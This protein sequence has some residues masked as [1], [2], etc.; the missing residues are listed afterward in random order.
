MN[1]LLGYM[2]LGTILV[3]GCI[4]DTSGFSPPGFDGSMPSDSNVNHNNNNNNN[5]TC[6][7]TNGGIEICDEIDNDCNG[8]VD[9]GFDFQNDLDN[10]GSCG[11]ACTY[12]H[13]SGQCVNGN[14]QMSTCD[15]GWV[16]LN[17]DPDNGCEYMC[18]QT[19]G[20]VEICDNL[21]ND[22]DGDTDE[23]FD[24]TTDPNNCG[25]C[26][27]IC[28]VNIPNATSECSS[29]QCEMLD[30]LKNGT[31]HTWWDINND[32]TDGCE[33]QCQVTTGGH[34]VCDGLDNDCDGQIDEDC[35]SLKL[36]FQ[37]G[38]AWTTW[39]TYIAD[40][41]GNG[42]DGVAYGG[43]TLACNPGDYV[44]GEDQDSCSA[45]FD[46]V[47]GYIEV[48]DSASL[49]S[50]DSAFTVILWAQP[51]VVGNRDY[52]IWKQDD[53][54]GINI[55]DTGT[56]YKWKFSVE[57]TGADC[58]SWSTSNVLS[59]VWTMLTMVWDGVEF[60]FYVNS[61]LE[62]TNNVKNSFTP[63]TAIKIATDGSVDRFFSGLIDEVAIYN[64]SWTNTEIQKYYNSFQP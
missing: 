45:Q 38:D 39:P 16:D 47:D 58:C 1:A 52:L 40:L 41:S 64:R 21:D 3:S 33:Y 62:S 2:L 31:S 4:F 30:C 24:L 32:P 17:Q 12:P 23:G 60:R 51:F 36:L 42:N 27:N 46:G 14:C 63:G 19:N 34:E 53:R 49:D 5:N 28:S 9:E 50:I 8:Q 26:G 59:N 55:S 10:C 22:C 43:A 61:V 35:G 6:S 37:F 56:A 18:A 54:P 29:G 48:A 44:P 13:A 11:N 20:G 7:P 15:I 57:Y 25:F